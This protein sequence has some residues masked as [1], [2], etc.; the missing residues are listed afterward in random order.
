MGDWISNVKQLKAQNRL[1]RDAET[2]QAAEIERLQL[3]ISMMRDNDP[4]LVA[5]VEDSPS[6]K[7]LKQE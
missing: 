5:I 6:V 4:V 1:L 3:I 7:A 2:A